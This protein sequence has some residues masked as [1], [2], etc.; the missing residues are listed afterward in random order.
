MGTVIFDETF[1]YFNAQS[2]TL[3]NHGPWIFSE[4]EFFDGVSEQ[5]LLLCDHGAFPASSFPGG[6]CSSPAGFTC[7]AALGKIQGGDA[8]SP[9]DTIDLGAQAAYIN[10]TPAIDGSD[11]EYLRTEFS[12]KLAFSGNSGN[13][14]VSNTPNE[15]F[16]PRVWLRIGGNDVPVEGQTAITWAKAWR[17]LIVRHKP[18]VHGS[19]GNCP[20]TCSGSCFEFKLFNRK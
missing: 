6:G 7:M 8:C 18:D 1:E 20:A 17:I 2:G 5:P 9:G 3:E 16:Y 12:I 19:T 15:D 13:E 10:T 4:T 14:P 11:K